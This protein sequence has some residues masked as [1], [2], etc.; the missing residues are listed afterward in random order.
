MRLRSVMSTVVTTTPFSGSGKGVALT[1]VQ[2]M[3]PCFVTMPV[4]TSWT[5]RPSWKA[6]MLANSSGGIGVPSVLMNR[7]APPSP[8]MISARGI[9]KMTSRAV[10]A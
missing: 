9:F 5:S 7:R 6:R 8:A 2:M 3:L 10:L 4:S 1:L